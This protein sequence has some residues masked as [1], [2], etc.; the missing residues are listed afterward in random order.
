MVLPMSH[1]LTRSQIL[2]QP[3]RP[4]LR[5]KWQLLGFPV[6][7]SMIGGGYNGNQLSSVRIYD[8]ATGQWDLTNALAQPPKAGAVTVGN[9][10][11]VV[12]KKSHHTFARGLRG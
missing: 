6:A 10:Y 9:K 7:K 11:Y 2:G 8:P 5:E 4:C 12:W 3:R 1:A